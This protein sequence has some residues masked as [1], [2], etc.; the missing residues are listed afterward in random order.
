MDSLLIALAII[1]AS[2]LVCMIWLFIVQDCDFTLL[3][4]KLLRPNLS[5]FGGSNVYEMIFLMRH[6]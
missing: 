1:A 3:F 6:N 2:F 4:F 5:K